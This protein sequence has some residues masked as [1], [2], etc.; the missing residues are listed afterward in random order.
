MSN[1]PEDITVENYMKAG[2]SRAEATVVVAEASRLFAAAEA[3][4]RAWREIHKNDPCQQCGTL[5]DV[6]IT[7]VWESCNVIMTTLCKRCRERLEIITKA[8]HEGW[9]AG[10]KAGFRAAQE[11][12]WW[13]RL[14]Q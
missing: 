1:M 10:Y 4:E 9:D 8:R 12:P 3:N 13:R 11:R 6:E 2:A 14:F 7:D 5:E